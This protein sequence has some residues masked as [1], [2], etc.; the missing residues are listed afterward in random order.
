MKAI[1]FAA[2]VVS[3]LTPVSAEVLTIPSDGTR[4]MSQ[5]LLSGVGY[6]I[7]ASGTWFYNGPGNATYVA[8]AAFQTYDGGATWVPSTSFH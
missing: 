6:V 7:Q 5:A 8:D 2:A 3:I 1:L 4:V